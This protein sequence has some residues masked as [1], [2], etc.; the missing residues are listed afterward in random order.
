MKKTAGIIIAVLWGL[1]L[2]F[3]GVFSSV[4]TDG[5]L[6]ERLIMIAVILLI[7]FISAG[8]LAYFSS[9]STW[10]WSFVISAPGML[11][12]IIYSFSEPPMLVYFL[13]YI[14]LIHAFCMAGHKAA[15]SLKR[16]RRS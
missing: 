5:G 10:K 13:I 6:V 8:I 11:I 14:V 2:G 9:F 15:R 7:Y 3:F 12:L 1:L 4:F 16:T